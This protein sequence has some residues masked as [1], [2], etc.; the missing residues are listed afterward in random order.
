MTITPKKLAL[1]GA[2]NIATFH[3][4]ALR[5]LG[6]EITHCASSLN[7]TTVRKFAL[8]HNIEEVWNNPAELAAAHSQWDGVVISATVGPTLGL[9]EAAAASGK[10]VLVEKPVALSSAKLAAYADY[11]PS[12]VIVAYNRRHY[13]SVKLARDFV[14]GR[15]MVRA[16]M[17]LPETVSP[18]MDDPFY[19]IYENSVH[20]LDMLNYIFGAVQVEHVAVANTKDQF[21]GR[22]AQLR[23]KAG[24]LI[25]LLMNWQAPANFTLSI[26]DGIERLDLFPFEKFQRY[27]GMSVIEPSD[28]YPVRQYVPNL[29]ESGSVFDA[30][31]A[32]I[33]PGFFGQAREF[34]G[35]FNGE[36]PKIGAS[37]TDAYNAQL[38]AEQ[39]MR[40]SN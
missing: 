28:E 10:P 40:R 34:A 36:T 15:K 29:L 19:L 4:P 18:E 12:N 13:S 21:F 25:S 1:I 38:L 2:G 5:A 24:H 9:L 33:K 22:H 31:P 26:D 20:G 23:S 27:R 14:A 7:S 3:V 32:D 35:L 39:L 37:L 11:A 16:T 17:T 8:S 30:A 6:M